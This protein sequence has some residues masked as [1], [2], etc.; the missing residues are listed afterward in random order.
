MRRVL[1]VVFLGLTAAT[2]L[3]QAARLSADASTPPPARLDAGLAALGLRQ[4]APLWPDTLAALAPGCADP[5]VL[6]NVAVSG[7]GRDTARA[8]LA[9]PAVPRFV[10]LGYVGARA[11]IAAIAVRWA[12]ASVWHAV[13]PRH[14]SIPLSVVLVMLPAGCPALTR[15]DWSLLSP[16]R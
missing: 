15:L 5:L 6:A 14:G 7:L 10:Y 2:V 8:L 9:L 3:T 4:T 12:A 11:D 13:D 1:R 16:W